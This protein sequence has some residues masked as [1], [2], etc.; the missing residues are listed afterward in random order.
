MYPEGRLR[1]GIWGGKGGMYPVRC[2]RKG[3]WGGNKGMYPGRVDKTEE[4]RE[5]IGNRLT[6]KGGDCII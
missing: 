6:V 4:D 1:K 2:L 5:N 3:I